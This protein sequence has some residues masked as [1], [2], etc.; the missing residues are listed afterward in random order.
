MRPT[1]SDSHLSLKPQGRPIWK[2]K[3]DN[4]MTQIHDEVDVEYEDRLKMI[5]WGYFS[6]VMCYFK[7][8]LALIFFYF[9]F[10]KVLK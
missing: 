1:K 7:W 2:K 9:K 4:P 8:I 3:G 10:S 5:F 6:K